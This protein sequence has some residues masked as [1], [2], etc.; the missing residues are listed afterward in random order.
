MDETWNLYVMTRKRTRGV[1]DDFVGE[2][3]DTDAAWHRPRDEQ[4]MVAPLDRPS[5]D[6]SAT[7]D[8]YEWEPAISLGHIVDRGLDR[9]WRAFFVPGLPARDPELLTVTIGFTADGCLIA[10]LETATLDSAIAWLQRLADRLDAEVGMISEYAP[11][12]GLAE[13]EAAIE[14]GFS[15]VH[16]GW[17]RGQAQPEVFVPRGGH[18]DL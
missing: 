6:D 3:I 15:R 9:P 7:L 4:L 18:P 11:S 10:G 13:A 8:D 5:L 17:R 16:V 1:I 14:M 12:V 2:F